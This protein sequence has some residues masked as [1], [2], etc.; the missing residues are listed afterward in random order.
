MLH[1]L[2]SSIMKSI[3]LCL[4]A[5]CATTSAFAQPEPVVIT[6]NSIICQG[7][8]GILV[9][10]AQFGIPPYLYQWSNGATGPTIV[11]TQPAIFTVTVTDESSTTATASIGTNIVPSP[12]VTASVTNAICGTN[13][14]AITWT[15]VGGPTPSPWTNLAPG[16]YT[17]TITNS[18]GCTNTGSATVLGVADITI[19]GQITQSS[20]TGNTGAIDI[21]VTGSTAPYSYLWSAGITSEDLSNIPSA[22]YTVTVTNNAGCTKTASFFVPTT[23]TLNV[24]GSITPTGCGAPSGSIDLTVT[25][26]AAPYNFDWADIPGA[27]NP[28]DR[29]NLPVGTYFVIVVDANGCDIA[30]SFTVSTSAQVPV[31][32]FFATQISCN[33]A[34]T[35]ALDVVVTGGTPPYVFQWSNGAT[36]QSINNLSVGSYSLTLTDAI[37]CTRVGTANILQPTSFGVSIN[38]NPL[39]DG[40]L[41]ASVSIFGST[42]SH[43]YN[44]SNGATTSS[45]TGVPSGVYAV[46]VTN[47]LGCT[48]V[49][50]GL[51]VSPPA[52]NVFIDFC[53]G[54]TLT[55]VSGGAAPYTYQWN[56]PNGAISTQQNPTLP[57]GGPYTLVVTDINGCTT[58]T[59][60]TVT[61]NQDPCTKITGTVVRDLNNNCTVEISD[62]PLLNILVQAKNTSTQQAFF[63]W[64]DNQGI[65]SINVLPNANY[66][67]EVA[68]PPFNGQVCT[69]TSVPVVL[70][71]PGTTATTNFAI[72]DIPGC[73]E[74]QVSISSFLIRRC[75]TTTF[76]VSYCNLGTISAVDAYLDI[77]IDAELDLTQAQIPYIDLG[78]NVY[79]FNIGNIAPNQCGN[80]WYKVFVP[81]TVQVG[82]TFCT[83]VAVSPANSCDLA[84]YVGAL[85]SVRSECNTDTLDFIVKNIGLSAMTAASEYV[86]IEDGIMTMMQPINPLNSGESITIQVP[87]NGSTWRIEAD[88]VPEYPGELTPELSVE[89]CTTS[90]Q[91]STGFLLQFPNSPQLPDNYI[92]CNEVVGAYDPNDKLGLPL[93][94][95]P[96]KFIDAGTLIDYRIRFQ[97]TGNDTA[98]AVVI[99]DTMSQWL[100]LTTLRPGASSHNYTF[101]LEGNTLV[102]DFPN[103]MLPDSNVNVETSQGFVNFSIRVKDATPLGTDVN[104]SAAIYFDI[105][106]PVITNTTTHRVDKDF[107]Q[108]G[109]WEPVRPAYKISVQPN[110]TDG[111][112]LI[113]IADVEMSDRAL[114]QLSVQDALGRVVATVQNT[115]PQF[116]VETTSWASGPY[117]FQITRDREL[118]GNGKLIVR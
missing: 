65:Y 114:Y 37:G 5:L 36:T 85:L 11:V 59:Q 105:N 1:N 56:G 83:E 62:Q 91:F 79:R 47:S 51:L 63:G 24:T 95:G 20:C 116:T 99:R 112:A 41:N 60:V 42:G 117:W 80:F 111:L 100:D 14:G 74:L 10:T 27:N 22:T 29:S 110:P 71:A 16:N 50:S 6:G 23:S 28:E 92:Y 84:D 38:N 82:Q 3:L 2:T 12:L 18:E 98:F 35:G 17:V 55:S 21:T 77:T 89:G 103:I 54:T 61:P 32:T 86:V 15:V 70:G 67:V 64:T 118:I 104:N 30:R 73:T 48:A 115:T 57:I 19:T 93:G 43:T 44:W 7:Q 108:V 109:L 53:E 33:G 66:T 76:F 52:L 25:G 97:N 69:P 58:T 107:I 81:C 101:E 102:F 13:T 106:P 39:C 72:E 34:A 87:A 26:G 45:L 88:Q 46:T 96:N 4:F 9:A 90:G 40:T 75:S 94:Y 113:R 78:N 8:A 49:A 68:N 31:F